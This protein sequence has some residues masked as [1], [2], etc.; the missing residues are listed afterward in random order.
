[1]KQ[2]LFLVLL[3][4]SS[5]AFANDAK[6]EWHATTLTEATI[7]RFSRLNINIKN[8]YLMKC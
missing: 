6:N 5:L 3:V 7:K 2:V 8:V 1:M 4:S